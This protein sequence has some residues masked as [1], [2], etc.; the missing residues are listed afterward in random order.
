MNPTLE[1]RTKIYFHCQIDSDEIPRFERE[2]LKTEPATIQETYFGRHPTPGPFSS[3]TPLGLN[4]W[5]KYDSFGGAGATYTRMED[6]EGLMNDL[7][8][9]RTEELN[10]K[11]V[12]A[13]VR[14]QMLV[15]LSSY[16]E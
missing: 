7:G 11:K 2:G 5:L 12:L 16:Q 4:L 13:H 3:S 14:G 8:A 15:G 1:Q 9:K 10:G 6:I